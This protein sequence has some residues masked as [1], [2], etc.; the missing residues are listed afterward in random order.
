MRCSSV[1]FAGIRCFSCQ[2]L[3]S[4]GGFTGRSL[5][6]LAFGAQR[7]DGLAGDPH[8]AVADR[9]EFLFELLAVVGPAIGLE[10]APGLLAAGH[11]LVQFL[12]DA[13]GRVAELREP[14]QGPALGRGR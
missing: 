14:V 10:Y 2:P 8:F 13:P 11:L 9:L 1:A 4:F 3:L 6:A 12:E 7:A 5:S